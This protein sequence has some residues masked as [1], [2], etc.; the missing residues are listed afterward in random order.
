M[1]VVGQISPSQTVRK[2]ILKSPP[3]RE[4]PIPKIQKVEID[5]DGAEADGMKIDTAA[6]F[7]PGLPNSSS[8]MAEVPILPSNFGGSGTEVPI[9]GFTQGGNL[10]NTE[11]I[12]SNGNGGDGGKGGEGG[13]GGK[14]GE[15]RK[16]DQKHKETGPERT[17]NTRK[18]DQ[19]HKERT[20]AICQKK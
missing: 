5:L 1:P 6:G 7:P 16:Q 9:P 3:V 15:T 2:G 8:Q 13:E 14:R 17:R 20:G 4:D 18:Q 11:V 19:K 10:L 12:G